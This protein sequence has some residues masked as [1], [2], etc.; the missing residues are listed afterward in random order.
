MSKVYV[1]SGSTGE[2][3]DHSIWLVGVFSDEDSARSLVDFLNERLEGAK[4]LD[5]DGRDSLV[6][7]LREYDPD[8]RIYYTGTEYEYAE[9][10]LD[11]IPR[12][13]NRDS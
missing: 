12:A 6:D 1:V 7:S 8:M 4:D 3:S 13:F 5:W 9:F 2:Y 10:E 11:S